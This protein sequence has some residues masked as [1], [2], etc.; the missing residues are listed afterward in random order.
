MDTFGQ[1]LVAQFHR[2]IFS[3]NYVSVT[4]VA[5]D[6]EDAKAFVN[7]LYDEF[8]RR[9]KATSELEG[10]TDIQGI[11]SWPE[12]N[13][14]PVLVCVDNHSCVHR[15]NVDLDELTKFREEVEADRQDVLRQLAN[16]RSVRKIPVKFQNYVMICTRNGV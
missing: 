16:E 11:L 12:R 15:F 4:I 13:D 9:A 10:S 6:F 8:L 2:L 5:R 1:P 14:V 7:F 3:T